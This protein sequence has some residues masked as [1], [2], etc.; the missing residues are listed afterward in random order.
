MR[1]NIYF[2]KFESIQQAFQNQLLRVKWRDIEKWLKYD[3]YFSGAQNLLRD[4]S[5]LVHADT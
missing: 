2:L 4:S 5:M 3:P 1:E